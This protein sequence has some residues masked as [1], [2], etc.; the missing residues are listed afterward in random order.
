VN[1]LQ[2]LVDVGGVRLGASLTP[3]FRQWTSC[4]PFLFLL[5]LL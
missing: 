1:L 3:P 5:F 2:H 4:R